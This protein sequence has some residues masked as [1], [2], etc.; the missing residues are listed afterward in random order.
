M[1]PGKFIW[2]GF[3]WVLLLFVI[4][5]LLFLVIILFLLLFHPPFLRSAFSPAL[6]L[7][8]FLMLF[9]PAFRLPLGLIKPAGVM[10]GAI[11]KRVS[12]LLR[13]VPVTAAA[14]KVALPFALMLSRIITPHA[15]NSLIHLLNSPSV[16]NPSIWC[17]DSTGAFNRFRHS[18]TALSLP[19]RGGRIHTPVF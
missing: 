16:L 6:G 14:F 8:L 5:P 10:L 1:A 11:I 17:R 12:V 2:R 9:F 19:G 18:S 13:I 3:R 4:T 7:K 15:H